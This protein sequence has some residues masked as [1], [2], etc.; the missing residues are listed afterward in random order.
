[1]NAKNAQR[2]GSGKCERLVITRIPDWLYRFRGKSFS[3]R[4]VRDTGLQ[5]NLKVRGRPIKLVGPYLV[6]A[7]FLVFCSADDADSTNPILKY[8]LYR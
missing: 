3:I 8:C 1:M 6:I 5:R 4:R 7:A 2:V